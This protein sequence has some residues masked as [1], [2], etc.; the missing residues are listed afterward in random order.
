MKGESV[1]RLAILLG[2]FACFGAI[3]VYG[4][5]FG[6]VW[7]YRVLM[8]LSVLIGLYGLALSS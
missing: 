1:Q 2:V 6:Y 3:R 4:Q 5:E 8:W 7:P